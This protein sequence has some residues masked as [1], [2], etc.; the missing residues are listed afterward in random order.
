MKRTC[1][2]VLSLLFSV[3]FTATTLLDLSTGISCIPTIDLQLAL[4]PL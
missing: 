4:L 3:V 1:A 2:L